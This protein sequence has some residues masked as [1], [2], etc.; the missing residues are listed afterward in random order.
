MKSRIK[1]I[2]Y[3]LGGLL[4]LV[5]LLFTGLTLR[6]KYE[7]RSLRPLETARLDSTVAVLRDG[8]SNLY[9]L[10]GAEGYI[11]IDAGNDSAGVAQGLARL[12][13]ASKEVRAVL[14]THSDGDHVGGLAAFTQ[15]Q[16]YLSAAEAPLL[17]GRTPRFLC[18]G[19]S[20]GGRAYTVLPEA[21]LLLEGLRVQAI[22]L[23]GH[24]PG[25]VG[26]LVDG[27]R[28]FVGDAVALQNGQLAPFNALFEMDKAQAT[29]T[30]GKIES[31]LP[32][33][34]LYTAHYGLLS[35]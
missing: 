24:T 18:F 23:P 22:A 33:R 29:R 5:V 15:A 26:F 4:L 27:K 1:K 9:L 11:A 31:L 13:I 25:H 8:I 14:L 35:R 34:V 17:D 10:R 3:G 32:G 20:L 19:N 30:R 2:A 7:Q 21:E 6:V 28:L 16:V 12:G